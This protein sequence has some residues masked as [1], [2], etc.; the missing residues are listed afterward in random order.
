MLRSWEFIFFFSAILSASLNALGDSVRI[1]EV[2]ASN[3]VTI[4]DE[5]GDFED[6]IELYNYGEGPVDLSDWGLSDS[7][8]DPFKWAFP[9]G[10]VLEGG[11]YLI[12][13]ASGKDRNDPAS[14]LHAN[15]SIAAAGEEVI[16]S[17]TDGI[18]VDELEPTSIPRDVSIGRVEGKG[19]A[20][21]FFEV[22]TPGAVNDS[23]AYAGLLDPPDFS[24]DAGFYPEPFDLSLE[25]PGEVTVLYTLDGSEP[26]WRN[27]SGTFYVYK[28]EYPR[29]TGETKLGPELET[30][31][32][33]YVY[34]SPL[35]IADPTSEPNR[36]SGINTEFTASTPE[37]V[38]DVFKGAVVRARA[39]AD[40]MMPSPVV[41]RTFFV[42]PEM[43]ERYG[44]PVISIVA[45]G[46]GLFGY[47]EGL[48]VPGETADQWRLEN[49]DVN[50]R[51]DRPANYTQRG[52]KWER[53]ASLEVF[54][55]QGDLWIAQHVGLRIHG[56]FSRANRVKSLRLYARVGYG[57]D[58]FDFPLFESLEKR[59]RPGE[60][61]D[62]FRRLMLRNSGGFR[63]WE[64]SYYRDAFLQSLVSHVQ[65]DSMAYQP[66][67][68][69]INGEFWG[70][71]NIR[72][73]NDDVYLADH[74]GMD[75]E[76]IA[77]L[78]TGLE[79]GFAVDT[80][81]EEDLQQFLEIVDF[82][83]SHDLSDSAH[84]A[85]IEERVDTF[86]LA[87]IY[88]VQIYIN[89]RDWPDNNNDLW[90]K[91]TAGY[92]PGAPTG[93]D[94]RWRFLLY[95][96]DF[97]FHG[98]SIDRPQ[99]G[100][101][102]DGNNLERLLHLPD[103]AYR[104]GT[105]AAHP[106]NRLFREMV[107]ANDDYRDTFIN[108]LADQINSS[109]RV[110]RVLEMLDT[111]EA[112]IGPYREA[113]N[114]RWNLGSLSIR[115]PE[116]MGVFAQK[117]PD[118]QIGHVLET[119]GLPAAHG[120]TVDAQRTMGTVRVNSL[121]IDEDL[122]GLEN[123]TDPY[124]W[125]GRYFENVPIELEARPEE[126]YRF[127]GWRGD[128]GEVHATDERIVLSLTCDV[129]LEAVFEEIP[130]AERPVGLHVWDF[131]DG[132]RFPDPEFTL[133]G[134]ELSW[135]PGAETD[136]VRHPSSAQGFASPHLRV[137]DPLGA[138]VDFALPTSGYESIEL[139]YL[140][141]RSGS[142]AG[143]Q[144]LAYTTDGE[145]WVE[146]ET[147]PVF[148][149]APQFQSFDFSETPGVADNSEF[150]VRFTFAEGDGG[151]GGNNRFDDV[152]LSG[153]GLPG[154]KVPPIVEEGEVPELVSIVADDGPAGVDVGEWFTDPNDEELSISAS[155]ADESVLN[156]TMDGNVLSLAG[157]R[158]GDTLV[159][160][161]AGDGVNPSVTAAFRVLVYPKPFALAEGDFDFGFWSAGEPA[162]SFPEHMLFL[163]SEQNDPDLVTELNFAYRI[164]VEDAS[165]PEDV[166][167]P[168]A[169]TSRSRINGLDEGGIGFI[170][171]GRGR[172]LGSAVLALDT[173]GVGEIDVG[174][175]AG[176]V[177]PNDRIYAITLQYRLGPEEAWSDLLVEGEPVRYLRNELAGHEDEFG[178][179]R[180]PEELEDRELVQLQWRY[181]H[182]EGTS[183]PR[184]QL[185]LNDIVVTASGVVEVPGFAGWVETHFP[186]EDWDDPTVAGADVSALEDGVANLVKYALGLSPF[187]NVTEEQLDFG[188]TGDGRL[189]LRFY[190]DPAKTDIVY[191]V[192][193]SSDL[194]DWSEILYDSSD[195]PD[196]TN[197]DG[198]IHEVSV[199]TDG[200]SRRFLRLRVTKD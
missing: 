87:L 178:P 7:Y 1:N 81:G 57:A 149:A 188:V 147:Y 34:E 82:A 92:E 126:G 162:G 3:G 102:Y 35:P 64:R 127:A 105:V 69:F 156:L 83:E 179:L 10:T 44:L 55:P 97:G 5:D 32:S 91:R 128:D 106:V 187:E 112:R 134:G 177:L 124:P 138:E 80:G 140:T 199:E 151:A 175:T 121:T 23:T 182:I 66:A 52:P 93:H 123:A 186:E 135:I 125:T 73:R 88:A 25:A 24:H 146:V 103:G 117:R 159:T 26:D 22:P 33:S 68:H 169:A 196:G 161:A 189:Y 145:E 194:V 142:G 172:D 119:F 114:D 85:W 118:A 61:L 84:L 185:R 72:E 77:I 110:D 165:E 63:N 19:D 171:T 59:G 130:L 71:I 20:W 139:T 184:A 113:H 46:P 180:L 152:I 99:W 120:V 129:E 174:F 39:V 111:F 74:Y 9:E 70:L 6:W 30:E 48:Y 166:D 75:R 51:P 27:V 60:S 190:R 183:G 168:F 107:L 181:H 76:D 94:G 29:A 153:V 13:W 104:I 15:Y 14:E 4:A 137:N 176:T 21:F 49:P 18:R 12:V 158:A 100:F 43:E 198:E 157:Q 150:A 160:V 154:T 193:A 53:R 197:S 62:S 133:G 163:Q 167:F 173:T 192:E 141:R 38:G 50:W 65:L 47:E 195:D 16:L 164:P 17:R 98:W 45:D 31:V 37:P 54:S 109:F 36:I 200:E 78:T 96:L 115:P 108:V 136:V 28:N 58:T 131:D 2:M 116:R 79:G 11:D 89:N 56:G 191:L 41:T 122:A 8:G 101:D 90:R 132:E 144:T 148:D 42:H 95:D 143:L 67:I 86:N 155:S 170:N 40:G